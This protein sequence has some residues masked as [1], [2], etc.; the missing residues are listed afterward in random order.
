MVAVGGAHAGTG[1]ARGRR[2]S[3]AVGRR[4]VDALRH[5]H[6]PQD[7]LPRDRE[8][9]CTIAAHNRMEITGYFETWACAGA[10]ADVSTPGSVAV[11]AAVIVDP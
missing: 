10:H 5:D 8:T 3:S 1:R 7:D 9:L 11:G 6:A 4:A 2:R